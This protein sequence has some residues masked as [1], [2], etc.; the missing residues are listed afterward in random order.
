VAEIR[1]RFPDEWK[2]REQNVIRYTP[3]GGKSFVG[4]SCRGVRV[5]A[6]IFERGNARVVLADYA[7]FYRVI[8]TQVL[9]GCRFSISSAFRQLGFAYLHGP[10]EWG[11]E[12]A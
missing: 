6:Q 11:V 5:F 12:G 3:P 8:V 2:K 1:R 4:L 10:Q 9:G 7:G